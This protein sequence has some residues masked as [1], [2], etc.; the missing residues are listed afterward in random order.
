MRNLFES[1]YDFTLLFQHMVERNR[2]EFIAQHTAIAETL[3]KGNIN[4]AH[5]MI[6]KH[7]DAAI[8]EI[9]RALQAKEKQRIAVGA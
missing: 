8:P 4:S 2:G 7:I 6:D 9:C 5:Q 3:L 1:I